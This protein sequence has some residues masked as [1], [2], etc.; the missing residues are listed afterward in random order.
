[1]GVFR[2]DGDYDGRTSIGKTLKR[3]RNWLGFLLF[4]AMVVGGIILAL[5]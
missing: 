4:L 5:S 1:M 3:I 2:N